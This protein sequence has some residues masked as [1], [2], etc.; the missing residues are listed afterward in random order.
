L[1]EASLKCAERAAAL[2]HERDPV[3]AGRSPSV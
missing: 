3:T 1:V 2:Y